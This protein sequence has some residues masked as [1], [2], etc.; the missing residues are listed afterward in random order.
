MTVEFYRNEW[1]MRLKPERF[2]GT[3]ATDIPQ[4][5]NPF[6]SDYL[7]IVMSAP[8]RRLQDKAG[9]IPSILATASLA[10]DIGNPPFGHFGE[11]CIQTF[12][13]RKETELTFL[14]ECEKADLLSFDGN[15]QGLRLLLRLGL[16]SDEF[17]YNLTFPTLATTVKYPQDSLSGNKGNTFGISLKKY[18][19]Y[20]TDK[21]RYCQI[22]RSLGLNGKRHPLCFL[23]ESADDIC[24]SVSDIEDGFKKGTIDLKFITNLILKNYKD[25]DECNGL[26]RKIQ[27][28][29]NKYKAYENKSSLI[30]QECRIFAQRKMIDS[31]LNNFFN[32][33]DNILTGNFDQ[34]LLAG[35]SSEKLRR[36]F[37]DIAVKNFKHE[38][39]VKSELLGDT[40]LYYLL[41]RFF[42]AILSDSSDDRKTSNGKIYSLFSHQARFAMKKTTYKNKKYLKMLMV[43]DFISGMTDSYALSLYQD[44]RG[45]K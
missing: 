7:R 2:R 28:L 16:A 19:Y 26:Y 23:L 17:S 33:H 11:K 44:L 41:D 14:N 18:G 1:G 34:E 12:F 25:D 45:I 29:Q 13:K 42:T 15:I 37:E 30:I 36:L 4:G 20:Q 32:N 39:V 5:W 8:F 6:D 21:E 9:H 22:D 24:Y 35:S 43:I 40:V 3:T 27:K 38:S 31:A 10:H